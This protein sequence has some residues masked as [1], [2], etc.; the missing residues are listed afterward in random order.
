MPKLSLAFF[1]AAALCATGGMIWG[2]MMGASE[3]FTLAPAHAHLN[4]VGWT[5]LALMGTFYALSKKGGWLG[6]L[7]FALSAAAVVVM[8]PSLA[9]YLGGDK[10]AHLWVAVGSVLALAGMLTFVAVVLSSWTAPK[11]AAA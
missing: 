3:N 10:P 8:I 2:T 11:A 7:N 1:T 5:T 4:L 6:W 9:I